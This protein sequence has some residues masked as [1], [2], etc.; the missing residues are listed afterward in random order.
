M[1]YGIGLPPTISSFGAVENASVSDWHS[2]KSGHALAQTQ[3]DDDAFHMNKKESFAQRGDCIL[4]RNV[5]LADISNLS[6]Y[7]FYRQFYTNRGRLH[8]RQKERFL[9]VT[10]LGYPAQASREH[11]DHEFYA[12]RTLYAY[13]PCAGLRGTDYINDVAARY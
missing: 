11:A 3:D 2:L 10:G 7:A 8:V 9:T 5:E 4:P 13:M 1:H 6:F 12:K